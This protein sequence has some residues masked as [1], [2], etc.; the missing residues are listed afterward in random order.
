MIVCNKC[1]AWCSGSMM[2]GTRCVA[3]GCEGQ[4]VAATVLPKAVAE[5]Q[6]RDECDA[7]AIRDWLSDRDE[8]CPDGVRLS[9]HVAKVI[10]GLLKFMTGGLAAATSADKNAA[11][12]RAITE[13]AHHQ[14][15]HSDSPLELGFGNQ[16]KKWYVWGGNEWH[17]GETLALAL[18][19]AV[20]AME[21]E[22]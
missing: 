6:L 8:P 21:G 15:A 13:L 14:S 5:K 10:E 4:L 20:A 9:E 16:D 19:A 18:E 11:V 2:L 3:A 17:E 1:S 7:D 12:V 22:Q